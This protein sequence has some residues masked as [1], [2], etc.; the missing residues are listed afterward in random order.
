MRRWLFPDYTES[1]SGFALLALRLV[2]GAAFVG[3][4]AVMVW[5]IMGLLPQ[6]AGVATIALAVFFLGGVQLI[7]IG[8]LGEYL[9]R[10][11]DEVKRRPVAIVS[12]IVESRPD[13]SGRGG[14]SVR[15]SAATTSTPR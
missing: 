7:S 5:K 2:A 13:E 11:F 3:A 15:A 9:G 4:I 6:G 12:S 14:G 8:I 1:R 10:V